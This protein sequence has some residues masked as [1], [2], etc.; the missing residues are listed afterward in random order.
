M[1]A[2]TV[3]LDVITEFCTWF[4]TISDCFRLSLI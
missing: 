4:S 3:L 1:L 2:T